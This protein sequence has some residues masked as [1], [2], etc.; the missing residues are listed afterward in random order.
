[1]ERPHTL[2]IDLRKTPWSTLSAWRRPILIERYD[3]RY[4]WFG[5][6]LGNIN[7]NTTGPIRLA[8]PAPGIARLIA[9]LQ[10]GYDLVLL[11]G[12]GNYHD[13]H[14]RVVV[15]LLVHKFPQLSIVHPDQIIPAGMTKCLSIRQPWAWL[16]CHPEIVRETGLAAKNLENRTWST[17]FRGEVLIHAG[18]TPD[19]LF[20]GTKDKR[21]DHWY[22]SAHFGRAGARLAD[23]MPQRLTDYPRRAVVGQANLVDVLHDSESPWFVGPYA[24]RLEQASALERPI[25]Y[26]GQLKLFDVPTS[27]LATPTH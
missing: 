17:E 4:G 16:I 19:D 10:E 25:S 2:L 12:C 9:L 21:L 20:T 23:L 5:E 27:L 14:R 6:T 15:E 26:A 18:A 22:W 24:F 3:E 8:N 7:Y 11:C 1:M 13:C